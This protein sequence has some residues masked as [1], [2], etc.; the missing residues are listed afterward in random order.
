MSASKRKDSNPSKNNS[1]TVIQPRQA[2]PP[3][4]PGSGTAVAA[5]QPSRPKKRQPKVPV[6]PGMIYEIT[7][8]G[9]VAWFV[10]PISWLPL[11]TRGGGTNSRNLAITIF[12]KMSF[13]AGAGVCAREVFPT[14]ENQTS[15]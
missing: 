8:G 14:V 2:G 10:I 5:E 6:L 1:P 11:A 4:G 15:D 9:L 12:L 7:G 3:P 13:R